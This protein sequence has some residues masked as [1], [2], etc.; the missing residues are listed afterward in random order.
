MEVLGHYNKN[1]QFGDRSRT[2]EEPQYGQEYSLNHPQN[3][4]YC[5]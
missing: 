1:L 5:Q 2:S 3:K 4:I